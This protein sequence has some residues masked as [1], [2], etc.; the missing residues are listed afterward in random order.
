MR[1]A[2]L[3]HAM[4]PSTNK[5]L[6]DA[7]HSSRLS[8]PS[9]FGPVPVYYKDKVL[10]HPKE[11]PPLKPPALMKVSG[12]VF[13]K[14]FRGGPSGYRGSYASTSQA[15]QQRAPRGQ[16]RRSRGT[17]NP[18]RGGRAYSS[19]VLQP[20]TRGAG[21]RSGGRGRGRGRSRGGKTSRGA[22]GKKPR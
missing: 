19:Q 18:K 16:A 2:F 22:R 17:K 12:P 20:A 8:V 7:L 13:K 11:F 5:T 1:D 3:F 9:L 21:S 14:K 15:S 6:V 10:N 4:P